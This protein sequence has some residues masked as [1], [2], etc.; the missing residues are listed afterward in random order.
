MSAALVQGLNE[1]SGN[2]TVTFN[3]YVQQILP[4]DGF[5]FWVNASLL[6]IPPANMPLSLQ[7]EGS[8]HYDSNQGQSEDETIAV[9]NVVFTTNVEIAPFNDIESTTMYL[10]AMDDLTF[11]F[12]ARTK[13]YRQSG[14]YHYFGDA[15]Y[16]AMSTQIINDAAALANTDKVLSNSLPI[17]LALNAIMPVYPAYLVP[18]NLTPPYAVV[19]ILDG[20]QEAWQSYP[21]I[22]SDTAHYQ[23]IKE[24]AKIVIYG[25]RNDQALLFVDYVLNESLKEQ[26]GITNCPVVKD[27][28]RTQSELNIRGMKKTIDFEV[29]YYQTVAQS[30]ARQLITTCIPTVSFS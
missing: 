19:N 28:V 24:T 5:I 25:L 9:Q 29:N 12:T 13:F 21:Y 15:T 8:V 14:L 2:Q 30:I 26:F 10:G 23:L 1:L 4:V 22:D 6:A 11:S 3:L 7:V 27:M 17:W 20:S 16:P 18:T